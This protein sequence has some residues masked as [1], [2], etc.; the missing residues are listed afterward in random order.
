MLSYAEVKN[1]PIVFRAFTGLD[2]PE[3][4]RLLFF[5]TQAHHLYIEKNRI[6][7][8]KRHRRLG[9]GRRPKL[10]T[11]ADQLFFI[12]FYFKTYPLQEVLAYLFGLSQGQANEW[13]HRLSEILKIALELAGQLPE[14]DPKKLEKI[15]AKYETLEFIIDGTERRRQRPKDNEQQKSY[16]SGKK[17]AH[18]VLFTYIET[19]KVR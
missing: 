7:G 11:M 15:L 10:A 9:G 17:K 12:L 13:I 6:K 18:T 8:K 14:R 19:P 2:Y 1:N 5:F 4:E 3:F 16:Y